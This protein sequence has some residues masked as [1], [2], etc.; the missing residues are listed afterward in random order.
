MAAHRVTFLRSFLFWKRLRTSFV[1]VRSKLSIGVDSRL[2]LFSR[3]KRLLI[4]KSGSGEP[5]TLGRID[6]L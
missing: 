2:K 1:G 5:Y 4:L 3:P 6:M